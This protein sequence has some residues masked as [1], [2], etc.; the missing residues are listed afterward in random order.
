MK[1]CNGVKVFLSFSKKEIN[2]RKESIWE[3]GRFWLIPC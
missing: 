1:N 2:P 3:F